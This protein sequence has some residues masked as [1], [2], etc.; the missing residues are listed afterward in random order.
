MKRFLTAILTLVMVLTLLPGCS[1]DTPAPSGGETNADG[2]KTG[3]TI[4]I[5][6]SAETITLNPDGKTDG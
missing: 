2:I 4:I 3:G 1:G 5:G 6:Q